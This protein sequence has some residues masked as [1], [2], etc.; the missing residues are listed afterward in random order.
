M[1]FYKTKRHLQGIRLT[2]YQED[3]V[4]N[5]CATFG[6]TRQR[7]FCD[8]LDSF[9]A[10]TIDIMSGRISIGTAIKTSALGLLDDY[11]KLREVKGLLPHRFPGNR[12]TYRTSPEEV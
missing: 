11:I 6:I 9:Y 3:K 1:G 4:K 2:A 10:E 12:R 5:I 7:L 8:L